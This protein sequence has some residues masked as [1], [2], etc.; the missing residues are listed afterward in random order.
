MPVDM[1]SASKP[2]PLTAL[3]IDL[4]IKQMSKDQIRK[5]YTEGKYKGASPDL[6]AGYVK[7][8]FGG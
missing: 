4:R 5:N 6:V 3:I 1:S 2:S 8:H 7:E